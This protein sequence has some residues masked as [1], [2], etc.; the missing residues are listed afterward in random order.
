MRF[1]IFIFCVLTTHLFAQLDSLNVA[2]RAV[3]P[4]PGHTCA[5]ICG[6]VD[7]TGREYALVGVDN[8]MTVVDVTNPSSPAQVYQILWP[9]NNTNSEWKEIKVYKRHAYVVS[10]AGAGLQIVDLSK[11]PAVTAPT[12]TY[13]QPVVGAQTLSSVHALHIDTTKGNIYLYGS[14]VGNKGAIIGS[15]ANPAAPVYLGRFN[16]TY[17]HDGY[18]DND[19]LYACEIYSGY[20]EVIDCSNKNSPQVLASV[21]TPLVFT[22]NSWPTPD[23]KTIFT[24]DEKTKSSLTSYDISDLSNI[25]L[26]DTIKGLSSGSIVHNTHITKDSFAVTSWY[27]DGFSIVDC[28]RPNNLIRVGYYDMYAGSGNGFNGTWGVYPFLP[29]GTIVCS[30]IEDGLY[31]FTPTYKRAC[32]LEGNVVDS[33]TLANLQ[34]VTTKIVSVT[35]S[36]CFTD[37]TGNY[38]TGCAGAGTYNV[39]FSKTGYQTKIIN[40]VTLTNGV[41]TTLNAKLVPLGTGIAMQENHQTFFSVDNTLFENKATLLYYLSNAEAGN[42]LLKVY[43]YSGNIVLEKK[44]DRLSGEI[45]LGNDWSAGVYLVTLNSCKPQRIIKAK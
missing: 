42:S 8:G 9:V 29:S 39:Q 32:F 18:V 33:I 20:M 12:V 5:N 43:D 38:A 34:N 26:L 14:N 13:W 11:L 21:Q 23:K 44:L 2:F 31:V 37:V 41:V 17:V 19:T 6:Y 36:N 15:L 16:G 25:T 1:L 7:S 28:S 4:Y 35:S 22:H 40:N 24:T 10:E 3:L 30:N 27:R 45:S